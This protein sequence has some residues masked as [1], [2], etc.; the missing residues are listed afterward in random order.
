MLFTRHQLEELEDQLLAPYAIRSRDSKG[1]H[2]L[3]TNPIIAPSSS[4][5]E[6]AS[7]IRLPFDAWNTRL[8]FLSTMRAIITALV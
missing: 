2:I 6:T 5:I 3:R 4:A 1:R 7:F 8:R